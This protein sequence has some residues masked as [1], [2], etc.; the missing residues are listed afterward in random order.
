MR[1]IKQK[2]DSVDRISSEFVEKRSK[3]GIAGDSKKI[4]RPGDRKGVPSG[5]GGEFHMKKGSRTSLG[6]DEV[7]QLKGGFRTM[8][9]CY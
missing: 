3:C 1:L 6:P 2:G 9:G 7:A 5:V 8:G 4:N